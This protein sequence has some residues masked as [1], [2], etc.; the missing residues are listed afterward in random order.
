MADDNK[1]EIA[2]DTPHYSCLAESF[3]IYIPSKDKKTKDGKPVSFPVYIRRIMLNCKRSGMEMKFSATNR[4]KETTFGDSRPNAL[5][6]K[7]RY[8]VSEMKSELSRMLGGDIASQLV[9][10]ALS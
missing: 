7:T 9:N 3:K 10:A 2:I 6:L 8:K 5:K 1:V 4:N